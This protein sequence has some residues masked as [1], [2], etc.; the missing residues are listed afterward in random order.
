MKRKG[1]I[2]VIATAAALVSIGALTAVATTTTA[3]AARRSTCHG[4][5]VTITGNNRANH[6]RGTRH[7]DVINAMGGNDII[8][9]NGGNDLICSGPGND[10]VAGGGGTDVVYGGA[11]RDLCFGVPVEHL[12]YHHACEVH[13]PDHLGGT[14]APRAGANV[15]LLSGRATK[16]QLKATRALVRQLDGPHYGAAAPDCGA[17]S[18]VIKLGYGSASGWGTNPSLVAMRP[19]FLPYSQV[20]GEPGEVQDGQWEVVNNIPND[21]SLYQVPM[22]NYQVTHFMTYTVFYDVAWSNDGVNWNGPTFEFKITG[23]VNPDF[24]GIGETCVT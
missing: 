14:T 13:L 15:R 19:R 12:H 8:F 22:P 11:G 6:I 3:S 7:R 2:G 18:A 4:R 16:A 21:G 10:I 9:G 17:T 24:G 5:R 23:Y 20:Y 1:I